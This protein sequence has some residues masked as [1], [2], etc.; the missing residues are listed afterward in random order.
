MKVT[1]E[2]LQLPIA[3][4]HRSR[5]P[6]RRHLK[7]DQRALAGV[8][9]AIIP[10]GP[11]KSKTTPLVFGRMIED[12]RLRLRS[13]SKNDPHLSKVHLLMTFSGRIQRSACLTLTMLPRRFEIQ[14]RTSPMPSG[15]GV[16]ETPDGETLPCASVVCPR[17]IIAR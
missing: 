9:G 16:A 14:E 2:S 8:G 11:P 13:L 3:S 6:G 15:A 7:V 12:Y 5:H 1:P 10:C 4:G 17:A